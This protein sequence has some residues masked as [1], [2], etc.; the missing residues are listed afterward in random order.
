MLRNLLARLPRPWLLALTGGL[1]RLAWTLR[2]RRKVVL[3]NLALAFP[4]KS[5]AER[6]AIARATYRHLGRM[7]TEILLVPRMTPAELVQALDL[8]SLDVVRAAQ[9][10]GKGVVACT[11]HYGNWELLQAG[12]SLRGVP[13]SSISRHQERT[14][15]DSAL[16]ETRR[17]AGVEELMVK[18]GSTLKAALRALKEGRVLGYVID[19]N[20]PP[21]HAIFPTFFGVPAATAATPAYLALRHGAAVVFTVAVPAGG[22]R[23]KVVIEGP[24]QVQ[25]TGDRERDVLAF[26]QHLND[27]LEHYVRLHPECWYWLHRRWKTRPPGEPARPR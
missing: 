3:S 18:R 11:A 23:Y 10:Q 16:K 15:A 22:D 20:Q 21:R 9:A 13:I 6:R 12:A 7:L 5:E 8:D 1:A 26:M 27:R 17:Q 2:I 25:D 24:F 19:Q 4:E 14:R